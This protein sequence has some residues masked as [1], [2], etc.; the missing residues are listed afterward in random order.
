MKKPL[1]VRLTFGLD[2]ALDLALHLVGAMLR[3]RID[4]DHPAFPET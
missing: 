2:W 3:V 1:K 4:R